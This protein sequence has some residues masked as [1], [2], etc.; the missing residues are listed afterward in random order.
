[1]AHGT[2]VYGV[3]RNITDGYT[4]VNGVQRKI[5]KGLTLVNGVQR[6]IPFG[7]GGGTATI[8]I[9]YNWGT[10]SEYVEING[11]Q[12]FDATIITV[13]TGTIVTVHSGGGLNVNGSWISG[14][15]YSF[16]ASGTATIELSDMGTYV[17][18]S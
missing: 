6:E 4:L 14:E 5:K 1:M 18:T 9:E 12:Y 17:T 8:I 13:E 16:E 10:S 11:K 7:G 3:Q 2:L 15:E